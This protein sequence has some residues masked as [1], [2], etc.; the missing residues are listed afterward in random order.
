MSKT[1]A[2]I[3]YISDALCRKADRMYAEP[4]REDD[5]LCEVYAFS[6]EV[7]RYALAR[8]IYDRGYGVSITRLPTPYDDM[9]SKK[10]DYWKVKLTKRKSE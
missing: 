4:G 9:Y 7:D 6:E 2:M 8:M 5:R 3:D 1:D 10:A